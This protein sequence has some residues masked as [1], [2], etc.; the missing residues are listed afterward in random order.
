MAQQHDYIPK[1]QAVF[2]NWQD[3]HVNVI[4]INAVDWGVLPADLTALQAL[5]TTYV[6]AYGIGSKEQKLTRTAGQ[7]RAFKVAEKNY[8]AGIR[9]FN[10]Q[11]ITKNP[12]VTDAQKVD[13]GVTVRDTEPTTIGAVNFAPQFAVDKISFGTHTLRFSNPE[14]PNSKSMPRG[15]KII[16]RIAVGAADI[17]E[18]QIP[19]S[20]AKTVK[21]FLHTVHYTAGDKSKTAYYKCCYESNRGGRGPWSDVVDAVVA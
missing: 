13:M 6:T 15:Q 3:N 5:Q 16:L 21:R 2:F 1:E 12:L 11:W 9:R 17:P 18:D 14:D 7:A 4:V 20:D 8:I 19:W 10:G